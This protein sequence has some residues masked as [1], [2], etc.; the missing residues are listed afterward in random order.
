MKFVVRYHY[1]RKNKI[2][3]YGYLM[4]NDNIKGNKYYFVASRPPAF[5]DGNAI[6]SDVTSK[7]GQPTETG[8]MTFV[9]DQALKL[10]VL[11]AVHL[12]TLEWSCEPHQQ[13]RTPFKR[14]GEPFQARPLN[15]V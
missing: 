14:E 11:F 3:V 12:L 6:K 2:N 10:R 15:E 13:A 4:V 8:I 1:K 5:R 9:P 7:G